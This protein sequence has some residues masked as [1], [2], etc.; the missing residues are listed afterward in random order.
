MGFR[1]IECFN[2][3]LLAKQTW[4]F[5]PFPE[6]LFVRVIKSHY[7]VNLNIL[8]ATSWTLPSFA[9]R[10][11]FFIRSLQEEGLKH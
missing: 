7:Y 6:S 8:H 2:Q 5:L 3:A 11:I 1:D 9:W 4:R 10:S